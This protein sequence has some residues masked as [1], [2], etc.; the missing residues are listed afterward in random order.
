MGGDPVSSRFNSITDII[1]IILPNVLII[2]GVILLFLII[3]GGF[4][5]ITS[6]GNAEQTEKGKQAITGAII[7]FAVMFTAYWIV[8]II[9]IITGIPLLNLSSINIGP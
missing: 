6:A 9:E 1:S 2:S 5:V 8:Q 4:T 3:F 7:G